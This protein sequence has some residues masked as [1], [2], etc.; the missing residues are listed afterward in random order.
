MKQYILSALLWCCGAAACWSAETGLKPGDLVAVVGDSITE[1][2]L[3][4]VFIEDYLLMCQPVRVRVVQ[5]GWGGETSWG[6]ADRIKNDMLRFKPTVVT[7]C[8]GMNDGQYAPMYPGKAA[9]YR[10]NQQK[11]V[12]RCQR[13]GVRLIVVGSPGCVDTDRFGYM[14]A[15]PNMYNGVLAQERDLARQV[16]KAAGVAF[17]D[18]HTPMID[19][20]RKAKA[21]YGKSYHVGGADGIHPDSNGQLVMAYA[22]LKALGCSGDIGTLTV[23]LAADTAEATAGHKVVSC[24]QAALELVS[25]RYPFCFYGEPSNPAATRGVVDFLP[26]NQDLNRLVLLARGGKSDRYRV[27][28]GNSAKEFSADQ[29][30]NGINLA[31]EFLDN[32]FSQPFRNV[33]AKIR[34]KQNFE[35]PLVKGLIHTIPEYVKAAPEEEAAIERAAASGIRRDETLAAAATAAVQPVRHKLTITPI[36]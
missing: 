19:V 25:T 8:F 34:A 18:V 20:M 28:W 23:D 15:D 16:A 30:A 1:Q 13:A 2:K 35:T 21:K 26:F 14:G 33:E 31:A 36:E 29:L 5:F 6:F 24:K 3:Y 22:F 32:P 17:A 12:E 4:S 11:I 27:T 10:E 9:R 7:T